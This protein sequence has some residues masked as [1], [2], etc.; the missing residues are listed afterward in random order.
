LALCFGG[1]FLRGTVFPPR[2]A[3]ETT[4]A[5]AET[6]F[7]LHGIMNPR[8]VMAPIAG[9]LRDEGYEVVNWGYPSRR[10]LIQDYA[11]DLHR[12]VE[13]VDSS[14][15]VHFVGFSL[16][17]IIVRYYLAR[18]EVPRRGRFVMIAPPN[19]G[20]ERAD[21][22]RRHAWF[23]WLY[24]DKAIAQLSAAAD[25]FVNGLPPPPGEFGIIAGVRGDGKGYSA[26]LPG[27][28]DGTVSLASTR[29]SGAADTMV[30]PRRH[31]LLL[32]HGPVADAA[33][34]FLRTGSFDEG[35][36]VPAPED[37]A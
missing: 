32:F 1:S 16:G 8:W 29:L 26:V 3:A 21:R 9:R 28:D 10:R 25:S 36:G 5:R 7:L 35:R 6:V 30:F 33:A 4:G 18:Y 19:H 22:L 2:A 23:R 14:R 34:V 12:A 37:P 17:A 24:G 31:T 13:A 11:A 27:D 15:R 20:A